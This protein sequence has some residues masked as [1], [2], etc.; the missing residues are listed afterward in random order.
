MKKYFNILLIGLL[1]VY[2]SGCVVHLGLLEY[3]YD[4]SA[5]Y[6]SG[7]T[8]FSESDGIDNLDI[9][10]ISGDVYVSFDGERGIEVYEHSLRGNL[11][12]SLSLH[13]WLDGSTLKIKYCRSGI[14]DYDHLSKSL[15]VVFPKGYKLGTVDINSVSAPVE[16]TD[17]IAEKLDIDS[18]SGKVSVKGY[19]DVRTKC[20]VDT[21]S[22]RISLD[23]GRTKELNIGSISGSVYVIADEIERADVDTT[24][25]FVRMEYAKYSPDRLEIDTTSGSIEIILPP[26]SGF[27]AKLCSFSGSIDIDRC[28]RTRKVNNTWY[29]GDEYSHIEVDSMSGSI[30]LSGRY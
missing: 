7:D 28:F 19:S 25:G 12:K 29:C 10:W 3:T 4:N 1:G 8:Y 13:Y 20:N 16:C 9:D 5:R 21:V 30:T 18:V 26:D 23:L 17:L 6:E 2:L 27:D 14:S 24:S 22:G 15:Y 11:P